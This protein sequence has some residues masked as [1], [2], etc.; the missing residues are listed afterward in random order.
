M[1]EKNLMQKALLVLGVFVVAC[2]V[3]VRY[4]RETG[5]FGLN[6]RGGQD[7]EGGVAMIFE[8]NDE[9]I[10]DKTGLAENMRTLLAKR[11]DPDGIYDL[12]W[13][14]H[15]E[16]RIEVQM[17]LPPPDAKQRQQ[18]V[19][20]ATDALFSMVPTR[21]R[22]E[23]A[24]QLTGDERAAAIEKLSAG[25]EK[26]K[27]L[28]E[29]AA[30][31]Y[32]AY[33]AV[34]AEVAAQSAPASGPAAEELALK[35]QDAQELLEDAVSEALQANLNATRF[36]DL[37]A[38]DSTS[39]MRK[40][41]L[42]STKED[43]P[44]LAAKID[45][46]VKTYDRWSKNK[47]KLDGPADLQRLLKGAGVL[48]FRILT[49]PAPERQAE[50]ENLRRQLAE[51]GPR[52]KAGDR[53]AWFKVD[54]PVAF[55]DLNRPEELRT[56]NPRE[57]RGLVSEKVN[58]DFYV[59]ASNEEAGI[60]LHDPQRP[61]SLAH[62]G[63]SRDNTGRPNVV[64]EFD[65]AGAGL[66]G[67]LT[68][69]NINNQLAIFVDNVAY[70]HAT[71][72]SR[73]G[74]VGE[75]T[76][77]FSIDKVNY[78]VQTMQAGALPARLKDTPLSE[79]VIGSTLGQQNLSAALRSALIALGAV[80][81]FM[82][83]YYSLGGLV[84]NAA[85]MFNILLTLA[86]TA[87]LQARLTLP[88]I[89]GVILSIGMVVDANVL[90]FE[91][92]R[93]EKERG[94]SLRMIIK[95]GYDKALSTIIDSNL[96]TLLTCL[97]LYY[98]GSEEVKGFGLTLGAGV[99]LGVFTS[100]WVTR[101]IFGLL[102]KYKLIKDIQML[103]MI[104][105]PNVDWYSMRKVFIPTSVAII[106]IGMWALFS[107]PK[108]ELFDVEFNG[109]VSAEVELKTKVEDER[110]LSKLLADAANELNA[111]A[112]ELPKA[113]V[114]ASTPGVF[115]LTV[116]G[117][118]T[119][120]IEAIVTEPLEEK[121]WLAR[122]GVE[123]LDANDRVSLRTNGEHT[124]EEMQT[125]IRG[126]EPAVETAA[127][128]LQKSRIG[129]VIEADPSYKGRLWNFVTTEK[130][131]RL[132]QYT[133]ERAIGDNLVRQPRISYQVRGEKEGEPVLIDDNRI[134]S[135]LKGLPLGIGADVTDY[136]G[137]AAIWLED[138]DPPQPVEVI[139]TRLQSMRLQPGYHDFPYRKFDVLGV[140]PLAD[141]K[142]EAGR[143]LHRGVVITVVDPAVRYSEDPRL[144][145]ESFAKKELQLARAALDTEQSLRR[146]S[147]F[148]PQVAEQAARRAV[149][150]LLL[151]WLMIIAYVWVR[152]GKISYGLGGVIA[153]VHDVLIALAAV[154][155]SGLI[156]GGG[157]FFGQVLLIDDF[158]I[159]MTIVAALLTIIGFSINDTIVI[160]DRI[161]ELRGRMI[162]V[163]PQII[164]D[165]INQCM[166]RT[167]IT[168]LTALFT[169]LVMYIFGG[170]T[171]RPFNFC[172]LVGLI[173]GVYSSVAIAAPILLMG[174]EVKPA[175][176]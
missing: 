30:K 144:W 93:E 62:A 53:D 36:N 118:P 39:Q 130:N 97:I 103:K 25:T 165:A 155:I 111:K 78:L 1:T 100:V 12:T 116:P 150:A 16:N 129:T 142:D 152:F 174:R 154:G 91:R 61:W 33:Q 96:T 79:R 38:M 86:A 60:L 6:L 109:G 176:G 126:L 131:R 10:S 135:V 71:I 105:T 125:F 167:I 14:V 107:R 76:G 55:F 98:I 3:L 153:L 52:P 122:G 19:V 80:A 92:M 18:E 83:I 156:G 175:R 20:D 115:E 67:E 45:E 49:I 136:R 74:R 64:F 82:F 99:V 31:R 75:I 81:G 21:G 90:I 168:S 34:R 23:A 11:V 108:D 120:L 114:A 65:S 17:P 124:A 119:R 101:V 123:T 5:K 43:F 149:L 164:N 146:V 143:Q 110:Q 8:I 163:T 22:I 161:R 37:L 47:A 173:T 9:G 59:L 84:A 151:S 160:F 46:V 28:L 137:G 170:A 48:E 104:G 94:A 69:R 27:A 29:T 117:M 58:D 26:R 166:S 157:T 128:T 7:I 158:R 42:K 87:L 121:G 159:D 35:L 88:G 41:L 138:L 66:F 15:G 89:A 102:L 148:K 40:N 4:D 141:Q 2:I 70:S 54:N 13:R 63:V 32:D 85:L 145:A 95:N 106:A 112:A 162:D 169:V 139:K 133:L 127:K 77:D 57:Y 113:T 72:R 132:V 140:N 73:I 51:E 68:G 24:L 50:F 171:I 134:E 44:E 172:M 56:F 147:Q